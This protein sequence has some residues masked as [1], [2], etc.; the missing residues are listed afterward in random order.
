LATGEEEEEEMKLRIT[1]GTLKIGTWN[2]QTL[3]S[4]GKLELLRKEM[5]PY[6]CDILGLAEMRWTGCGEMN[7]GEVLWS[8][9]EKE[10]AR[11][12]GFLLSKRA[13][14]A[15]LGY[16]PIN[17]RMMVARFNAKPLNFAVVQVYAPTADSTEEDIETFYEQ[18]KETLRSI[19]KKDMKLIMGDWNAKVGTDRG[20]WEHVMGRYGFGTRNERG[21]R[22]LEFA[23]EQEMIICNTRF[24]QKDCRKWTWLSPDGKHTN[25]IDMVLVERRWKTAVRNCRTYQ[26]ADI[27]SDH[28]LVLCNVKMRLKNACKGKKKPGRDTAALQK[29]DI[30]EAYRNK[31][32]EGLQEASP[33]DT[34]DQVVERLNT[35]IQKAANAVLPVKVEPRKPWITERTLALSEEK[36]KLK[37]LRTQSDQKMEM[38]RKKCNEVRKAA[39]TDKENWLHEQCKNI[40][41]HHGHHRTHEMYQ[42][43]K[44]ISRSWQ[45]KLASIRNKDGKMLQDKEEIKNRW[46]EYC[47]T[48]YQDTGTA[49]NTVDEL[50]KLAPPPSEDESDSILYEEVVSAIKRLKPRKSTGTDQ[51]SGEMI[52]AGGEVL[53]REIHS[54]CDRIWREGHIPEE[55]TRSVLMVIPKKGDRTECSNYRTIALLNHMCKVLMVILL[56]RLKTQVEPYLAEEQAGFRRDRNT[57][58]QILMLRLIAEKA[59]RKAIPVYNCFVDFQKA[60]DSIKHDIIQ[61]TLKSYGVGKTLTSLIYRILK[62]AKAAVR[63]GG[64]LGEWFEVT[65]GS[66]QGDPI[67]PTTFITY[68]ERVMDRIKEKATGISIH[69]HKLSNLKFADDIDLIEE[70]RDEL[71]KNLRMLSTSGKA[72]GL[73]IN[74]KKTKTMVFGQQ[75]IGQELETEEGNVEN[76]TEFEYLGSLITWDND[77]T[78][79]IKRRIG[80]ATGAMAGFKNIWRSRNINVKTK[81]EILKTCVFS[82]LLYACETWTLKKADKDRLMA[83]EMRCYRRILHIWWQQKIT[84]EEVRR[85]IGRKQNIVQTIMKRKLNLFG[86]ICRMDDARLVKTVVFGMMEGTNRKGRPRREW[87]DDITEWCNK[88]DIQTIAGIAQDRQAWRKT[89]DDALDTNGQ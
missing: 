76:V 60:F 44:K 65:V 73:S 12:V 29:G 50:E 62:Q 16:F 56:E 85:R 25:M 10:H 34:I 39:R 58:Q 33:L 47:R 75:Q 27:A 43:I 74:G 79:E 54:L 57:T 84:N 17:S 68:L 38:Y 59:H 66:R 11:G 35:A 31:L 88:K 4:T 72:A 23:A 45:P 28:S 40:E 26:G 64:E 80:K 8:G 42:L 3:W 30:Q 63:V 19:P 14:S 81:L 1:E 9:E 22:M 83:F 82:V 78:A 49:K 46:T 18:L 52:Q 6:K 77:G 86:H 61:A 51:I 53:A 36:R 48:L 89:V 41:Q 2:V 24:Q 32:Q 55:W 69:G 13:Q 87:L 67:S 21:E 20:G 15:L 5:E 70:S 37:Q 71:Q 7:G